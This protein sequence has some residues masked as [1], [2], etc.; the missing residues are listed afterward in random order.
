MM[1]YKETKA[2]I[3]ELVRTVG[4]GNITG[5]HIVELLNQGHTGTNIQNAINYY[6]YSPR[7]AKY[8]QGAEERG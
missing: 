6:Q 2:A 8:R 7:A 1:T 3:A 4:L 5:Y